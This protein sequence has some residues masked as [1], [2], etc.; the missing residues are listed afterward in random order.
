MMVHDSVLEVS[1]AL[2]VLIRGTYQ[3]CHLPQIQL[4]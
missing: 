3:S 1:I 2:E 4:Q